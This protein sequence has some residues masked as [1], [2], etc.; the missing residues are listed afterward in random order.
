M[1]LATPTFKVTDPALI[2]AQGIHDVSTTQNHPFLT[3]VKAR[4]PTYGPAEFIYLKGVAST[5]VGS[6]VTFDEAGVTALS[7]ADATGAVAVA[8]SACDAATDFGWYCI[9]G[10]VP[11]AAL[12]GFDADNAKCFLTSTAGSIDDAVVKADRIFGMKGASAVDTGLAEVE[13]NYPQ[14]H[15]EVVGEYAT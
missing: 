6:V 1:A 3:R 11:A 5:A 10:K 14:C 13:L 15:D 2:G 4:C 9:Y 12:T 8:M 7:V